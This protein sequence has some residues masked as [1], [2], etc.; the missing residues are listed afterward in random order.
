LVREVG[1]PEVGRQDK[2]GTADDE[3]PSNE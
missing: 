3:E 1:P 2:T